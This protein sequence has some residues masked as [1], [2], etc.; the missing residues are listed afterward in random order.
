MPIRIHNM[1]GREVWAII[2][3]RQYLLPV[4]LVSANAIFVVR[5]SARAAINTLNIISMFF[6]FLFYLIIPVEALVTRTAPI[7]KAKQVARM[8]ENHLSVLTLF[9]LFSFLLLFIWFFSLLEFYW[10][11]H[12][13]VQKCGCGFLLSR[14]V[15][16]RSR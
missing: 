10:I 13:F 15:P 8:T 3:F 5:I 6:I 12:Y 9:L 16:I 1:S 11:N 7:N 2:P 14:L 4:R